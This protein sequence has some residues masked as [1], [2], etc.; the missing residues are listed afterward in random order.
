MPNMPQVR[1]QRQFLLLP[2]LLQEKLGKLLIRDAHV[3]AAVA[4]SSWP[5]GGRIFTDDDQGTHK[6][7]HKKSNFLSHFITPKVV[8]KPDPDTGLYNPFP[9]FPF[10][11]PLRPVYPLSDRREVPKR[12]KLPDYAGDGVPKSEL[13]FRGR[14]KIDILDKEA[15]E[16]MRKVCRLGREVLDIAAAAVKPG[17]TTDYIDEVVHKAT[18]ERDVSSVLIL[19]FAC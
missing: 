6:A 16:K 10:T 15:Q 12:I 19:L 18:L 14:N 9:T 11:G 2:G 1:H 7:L 4:P 17:V 3:M 8:S 5:S 13:T